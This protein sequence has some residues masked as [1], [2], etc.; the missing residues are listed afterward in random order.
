MV[1]TIYLLFVVEYF[2]L[3][4]L[5]WKLTAKKY[6]KRQLIFLNLI[7]FLIFISRIYKFNSVLGLDMDEAMGAVNSWSLGK[8]GVD[9]F[10][11]VHN[12]IYLFAWGSGMNI[13]YPLL[14]VPFIKMFGLSMVI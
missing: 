9:Y 4:F 13:L 14:T 2:I 7:F 3:A 11:L 8:Y 6:S 12:P 10:N 5:L 1:K